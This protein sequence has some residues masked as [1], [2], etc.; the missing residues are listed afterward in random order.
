MNKDVAGN[1]DKMKIRS[2]FVSNSSSSSF[3]VAVEKGKAKVNLTLEL[4]LES[5]LGDKF[6]TIEKFKKHIEDWFSCDLDHPEK[7]NDDEV[8]MFEKG[9][10]AIESGKVVLI[11]NVSNEADE[12]ISQILYDNP[13]LFIDAIKKSGFNIDIIQVD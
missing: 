5:F 8:N 2:N 11:G 12:P 4:D 9:K 6:T 10:Q 7:W 1:G 3:I 13:N